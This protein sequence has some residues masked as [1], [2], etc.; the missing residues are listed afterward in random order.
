[1]LDSRGS[2]GTQTFRLVVQKAQPTTKAAA[3][4]KQTTKKKA[5]H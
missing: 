4:K 3:A 1:M 5:R 2:T